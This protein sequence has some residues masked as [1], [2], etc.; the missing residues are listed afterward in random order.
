M[1]KLLMMLVVG[2]LV[3]AGTAAYAADATDTIGATIN[4]TPICTLSITSS[5]LAVTAPTTM[6]L[7]TTT[8]T[9]SPIAMDI[10][11]NTVLTV[12]SGTDILK[13]KISS[14]PPTNYGANGLYQINL[15]A[16]TF[17]PDADSELT[18]GE[19]SSTASVNLTDSDQVVMEF[20]TASGKVLTG[21]FSQAANLIVNAD[22]RV[23]GNTSDS[24]TIQF[25]FVD[26]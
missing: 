10:D 18:A 5:D 20:G 23:Y 8:F 4:G 6:G 9:N 13:V 22:K 1:R 21:A 7:S 16:G 15:G 17:T 12:T 14:T 19:V 2:V 25:T 3:L 11:D 26:N 24:I